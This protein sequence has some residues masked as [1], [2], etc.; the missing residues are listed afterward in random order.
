MI[1]TFSVTSSFPETNSKEC[2]T[3]IVEN[4]DE[5]AMLKYLSSAGDVDK[6][7]DLIL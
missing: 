1:S 2:E 7:L 6:G 5:R 3:V 4:S